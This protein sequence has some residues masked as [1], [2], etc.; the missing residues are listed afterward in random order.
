MGWKPTFGQALPL[1]LQHVLAAAVGCVTPAILV[2]NAANNAAGGGTVDMGLLIQMSLVFAGLSTFL[3]V[4]W[5]QIST[6]IRPS[7]DHRS[8]LCLCADDDGH[9]DPGERTWI[10]FSEP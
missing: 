10:R 7:G 5:Q 8:Q 9:C 4:V 1:A 2:A 6:G 3:S